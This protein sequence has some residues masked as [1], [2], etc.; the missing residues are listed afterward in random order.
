M[1]E[2]LEAEKELMEEEGLEEDFDDDAMTQKEVISTEVNLYGDNCRKIEE[3]PEYY[4]EI[5][6]EEYYNGEY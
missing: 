1:E 4:T 5:T 6:Q 2:E 3:L